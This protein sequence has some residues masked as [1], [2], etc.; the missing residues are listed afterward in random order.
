MTVTS[1][2][3]ETQRGAQRFHGSQPDLDFVTVRAKK[4]RRPVKY[5]RPRQRARP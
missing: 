4:R 2:P 3:S 1:P 5:S